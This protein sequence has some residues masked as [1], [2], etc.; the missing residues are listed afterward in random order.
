MHEFSMM[1]V[2]VGEKL[3][4]MVNSSPVTASIVLNAEQARDMAKALNKGAA[5]LEVDG[6]YEKD[7]ELL[8]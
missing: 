3:M 6:A 4:L 8:S 7:K 2:R 5:K 1:L